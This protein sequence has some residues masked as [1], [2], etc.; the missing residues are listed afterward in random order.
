MDNKEIRNQAKKIMD[1]FLATLDKIPE[2]D[3]DFGIKRDISIR[4]DMVLKYPAES[5]KEQMFKNAPNVEGDHIVAEKK[6]W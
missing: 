2:L 1:E 4:K 3:K 5:F 6:K